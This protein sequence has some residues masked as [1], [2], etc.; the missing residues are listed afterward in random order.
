MRFFTAIL[1]LYIDEARGSPYPVRTLNYDVIVYGATP[2]G[3][4]AAVAASNNTKLR[5]ALLEPSGKFGGMAGPG[6]IGLRDHNPNMFVGDSR[7]A[8]GRWLQL[9][10]Q[11]YKSNNTVYQPDEI[12]GYESWAQ[13]LYSKQRTL[14][15]FLNTGIFE[16][17]GSVTMVGTKLSELY[18]V[19]TINNDSKNITKWTALVFIDASYEADIVVAANISKTY[20]RESSAEYNESLAGV[21][22]VG[23]FAQFQHPINP[24]YDNGSLLYGIDKNPLPPVGSADNRVMPYSYRLC[25]TNDSNNYIPWPKPPQYNPSDFEL[26]RRYANSLLVDHPHGAP[27]TSFVGTLEYK[28]YPATQKR[29]MRF[30]LCESG[31]SAVSTDEPWSIYDKYI[32]GNRQMRSEVAEQV[33]YWVSGMMYTL[34]NDPLI[35]SGTRKS[36]SEWGL[37]ADAWPDNSNWPPLLYVREGY[38]I[39]GDNIETQNTLIKGLRRAN[40]I[41]LGGWTIDVHIINR[42]VGNLNGTI[43]AINEGEI[44]FAPLPGNGSL[45]ELP[46]SLIL[47]KRSEATNLLVTSCP[48]AS[49][50]AF[51]SIRVEP[52]FMQLGTAAGAAAQLVA[53]TN[54]A[55][56]LIDISKLQ[57]LIEA[58]GQCIHLDDCMGV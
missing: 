49:H 54:Q 50:V 26:L 52:T 48:S 16:G 25:V 23:K 18:T 53:L 12:V 37:C 42:V 51:A 34:S 15:V 24:Y 43:S 57:L 45:Y 14:D 32:T 22:P 58:N 9:N 29:S 11:Y 38:R 56:Q 36:A 27:I 10:A 40:S 4:A 44:G 5:V 31:G 46:Y 33:K 55:A 2:S 13:I 47:P 28:G 7:S 35:P 17:K 19:N 8:A 6:G 20:G 21:L 1:L 39:I 30:D 41:G 3:I